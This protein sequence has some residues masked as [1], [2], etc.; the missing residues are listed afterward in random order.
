[1]QSKQV[2]WCFVF[3][4]IQVHAWIEIF[5]SDVRVRAGHYVCWTRAFSP[6]NWARSFGLAVCMLKAACSRGRYS[7]LPKLPWPRM[8]SDSV[9]K[10]LSGARTRTRMLG[11]CECKCALTLVRTSENNCA[12]CFMGWQRVFLFSQ[13]LQPGSPSG[14]WG[15][16]SSASGA[17]ALTM[18]TS[19]LDMQA[20]EAE[21]VKITT[22]GMT[23]VHQNGGNVVEYQLA[24]TNLPAMLMNRNKQQLKSQRSRHKVNGGVVCRWVNTCGECTS[25]CTRTSRGIT[26][27]QTIICAGCTKQYHFWNAC[28]SNSGIL[29]LA[30]KKSKT[31]TSFDVYVVYRVELD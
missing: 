2:N 29:Q 14:P 10:I 30:T 18:L 13:F 7:R 26:D 16:L 23:Q 4:L 17:S 27:E 19:S 22:F 31:K 24:T 15:H 11:Q 12:C 5:V 25:S 1:M 6:R 3:T 21:G 9:N 20:L 8:I 28:E